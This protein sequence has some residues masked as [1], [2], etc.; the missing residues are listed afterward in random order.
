MPINTPSVADG[1][2]SR[3]TPILRLLDL[4]RV[5]VYVLSCVALLATCMVPSPG[6]PM[7]LP[8]KETEAPREATSVLTSADPAPR[9]AV[10]SV[11]GDGMRVQT[12]SQTHIPYKQVPDV[13]PDERP[14]GHGSE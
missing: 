3:R 9:S 11:A 1:A 6:S 13:N 8:A 2:S 5:T 14:R 4:S 7:T 10:A 12:N